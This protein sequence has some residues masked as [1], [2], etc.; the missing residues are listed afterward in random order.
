MLRQLEEARVNNSGDYNDARSE[1]KSRR[2]ES[3]KTGKGGK[4]NGE[5]IEKS[6]PLRTTQSQNRLLDMEGGGAKP[7]FGKKKLGEV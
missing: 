7:N 1:V 5:S 2:S 3:T 6:L 4:G